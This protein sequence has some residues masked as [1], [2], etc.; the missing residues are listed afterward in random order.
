MEAYVILAQEHIRTWR[1]D[2]MLEMNNFYKSVGSIY[3]KNQIEI[4]CA[5]L[6]V[7]NY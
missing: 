3:V 6:K 5:E 2:G 4:G 7:S 1:Y